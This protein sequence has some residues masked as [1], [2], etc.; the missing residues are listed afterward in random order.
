MRL[1]DDAPKQDETAPLQEVVVRQIALTNVFVLKTIS[2]VPEL[3]DSAVYDLIGYLI[4][5]RRWSCKYLMRLVLI[6]LKEACKRQ[7]Q[8]A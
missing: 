6:M 4:T 3:K 1:L 5:N 8:K 2:A 7:P